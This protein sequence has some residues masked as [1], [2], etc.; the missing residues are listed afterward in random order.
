MKKK[1]KFTDNEKELLI[2]LGIKIKKKRE[3]LKFS[4]LELSKKSWIDRSF[5]WLLE[6]W[7]ANISFLKLKKIEKILDE[8]F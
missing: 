7:L 4:Q 8:E 6:V 1:E 3:L 5:I 2:N